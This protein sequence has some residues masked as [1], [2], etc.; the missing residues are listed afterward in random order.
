MTAPS[1]QHPNEGHGQR[2]PSNPAGEGLPGGGGNSP[3]MRGK[4]DWF[5]GDVRAEEVGAQRQQSSAP[6]GLAAG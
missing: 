2:G 1:A 5:W 6:W 3:E 4:S